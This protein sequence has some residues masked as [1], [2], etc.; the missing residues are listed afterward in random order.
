MVNDVQ[1][2]WTPDGDPIINFRYTSTMEHLANTWVEDQE[3]W[4]LSTARRRS[5][6]GVKSYGAC[7][8][9]AGQPTG[10]W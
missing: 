9:W 6:H 8:V 2:L 1:H 3:T 10:E 4:H 7:L 5:V